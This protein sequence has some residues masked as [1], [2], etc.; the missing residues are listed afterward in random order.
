MTPEEKQAFIAESVERGHKR[1]YEAVMAN[2]MLPATPWEE[3]TEEVRERIREENR[4]YAQE[5]HEFG[6][7]IS[8]KFGRT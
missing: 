4:R 7:S 5:M 3:L 2:S 1:E 8:E 6:K